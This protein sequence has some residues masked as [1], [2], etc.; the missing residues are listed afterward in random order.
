M[1]VVP[2]G[3]G[4]EFM[5][6]PMSS[7]F[8]QMSRAHRRDDVEKH[9]RSHRGA[10]QEEMSPDEYDKDWAGRELEN[11]V[12]FGVVLTSGA[13]APPS[14]NDVPNETHRTARRSRST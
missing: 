8:G 12:N 11:C 1:G 3:D 10:E 7:R 2:H 14:G 5:F 6:L 13:G 4:S 9:F